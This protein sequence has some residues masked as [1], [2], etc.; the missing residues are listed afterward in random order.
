MPLGFLGFRALCF[1]GLGGSGFR[2]FSLDF[3]GE[4]RLKGL[5]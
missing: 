5:G 4:F 3:L 2:G 1:L